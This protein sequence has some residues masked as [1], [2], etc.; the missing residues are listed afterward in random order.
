MFAIVQDA[1]SE[2]GQGLAGLIRARVMYCIAQH[3][4]LDVAAAVGEELAL[5]E[6]LMACKWMKEVDEWQALL[7]LVFQ[8]LLHATG[9][10]FGYGLLWVGHGEGIGPMTVLSVTL[11]N[12]IELLVVPFCSC[13]RSE[14]A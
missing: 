7:L 9:G 12:F 8:L 5:L 6:D 2:E 1:K 10:V 11:L 13:L 3:R 4:A 14:L